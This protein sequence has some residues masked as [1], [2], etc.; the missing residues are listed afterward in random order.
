MCKTKYRQL[1]RKSY[2]KE[3]GRLAQGMPGLVDGKKT[4]FLIDKQAIPIDRWKD[5]TYGFRMSFLYSINSP[6]S[7]SITVI[8]ILSRKRLCAN[9]LG[10]SCSGAVLRYASIASW[11]I[12]FIGPLLLCVFC[13]GGSSVS[14]FV[15][16]WTASH[17]DRRSIAG[18]STLGGGAIL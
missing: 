11:V 6:V 5:V 1:Y 15:M 13:T 7:S 9:C 16:C 12:Y 18:C 2:A 10:A 3:I 4:M 14:L 8:S 17:G